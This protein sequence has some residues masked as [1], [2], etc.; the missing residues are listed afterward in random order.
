MC[1]AY[2]LGINV[3]IHDIYMHAKKKIIEPKK[4]QKN[5]LNIIINILNI[6]IKLKY[7]GHLYSDFLHVCTMSWGNG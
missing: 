1:H 7:L 4:K 2:S 3:L 6:A 5:K